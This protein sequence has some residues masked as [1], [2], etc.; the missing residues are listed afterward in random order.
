MYKIL[1]YLS[2]LLASIAMA[3]G[4]TV[5]SMTQ[6][7]V[8][9]SGSA[10]RSGCAEGI[11]TALDKKLI[12]VQGNEK[13]LVDLCHEVGLKIERKLKGQIK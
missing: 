8:A 13:E 6:V 5:P 1:I 9:V 3:S 2:L 11:L 12:A 10:A 7:S 4:P